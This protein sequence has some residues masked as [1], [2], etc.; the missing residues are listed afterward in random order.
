MDNVQIGDVSSHVTH[1]S[2]ETLVSVTECVIQDVGPSGE[3]NALFPPHTIELG[4]DG[5]DLENMV[6]EGAL[7]AYLENCFAIE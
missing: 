6:E 4:L 3:G 5:A 2:A 7:W 1:S